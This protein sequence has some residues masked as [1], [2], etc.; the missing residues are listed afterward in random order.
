MINIIS[1][2]SVVGVATGTMALIVILSVYNGFDGIVRSLFNSFDPDLRITVSEG[3]TFDPGDPRLPAVRN[4]PGVA[5]YSEVVEENVLLRY[6]DRQTIARIK[7]VD[8]DYVHVTGIDTMM[9]DGDFILR[10]EGRPMTV[11]GEGIAYHLG[12]GL[13]FINPVNIY[14]IKKTP[15]IPVSPEQAVNRKFIFPSGIF[16]IEQE[17]NMQY[18]FVPIGFARDLLGYRNEISAAELKISPYHDPGK[19]QQEISA[20]L[21][22]RFTVKNRLQQNETVYKILRSEKWAIFFILSFILLVASFN[23]I[24]SLTMLIIDKHD[25]ITILRSMGAGRK[26]IRRIF[27]LEGWMISALG[28]VAGIIIGSAIAWG[29]QKYGIIKLQGSGSFIID[30]YPV[31]FKIQDMFLV[32]ATVLLIGLLAAWYPIRFI[33]GKYLTAPENP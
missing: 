3:K 19:V 8:E 12:I 20:L 2:I 25:D 13:T 26:M 32:L 7:G 24:G 18:V 22:D 16:S 15:G 23:V 17:R 11:V 30:A 29:Q 21:G 1:G 28:A 9:A 6:R 4:H 10:K 14:V 5:V 33:S 27:L 31:I